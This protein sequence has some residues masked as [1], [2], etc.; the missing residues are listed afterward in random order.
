M[1]RNEHRHVCRGREKH[2]AI[3]IFRGRAAFRPNHDL[4]P[5]CWRSMGDRLRAETFALL[6]CG[7]GLPFPAPDV[8]SPSPALFSRA[9]TPVGPRDAQRA[10]QS[11]IESASKVPS[12]VQRERV[13]RRGG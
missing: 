2:P 5:R 12:P 10:T 3:S 9:G 13:P 7:E 1:K 6:V 4:C 11:A 8:A